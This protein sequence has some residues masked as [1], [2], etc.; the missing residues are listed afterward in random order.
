LSYDYIMTCYLHHIASCT[1]IV[2]TIPT[3]LAS[4]STIC[5]FEYEVYKSETAHHSLPFLTR[6][7]LPIAAAYMHLNQNGLTGAVPTEPGR[8]KLL[9]ELWLWE[10]SIGGQIPS[11]LGLL[12]DMGKEV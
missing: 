6:C 9:R 11:E 1:S 4:L 10:N 3:E 12:K 8:L 5:E 2:G 7:H